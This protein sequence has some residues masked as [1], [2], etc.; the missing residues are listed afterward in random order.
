VFVVEADEYDRSFLALTPTVAVVNNVEADHLDIYRD[1]DDIT[2]AFTE[3][4]RRARFVVACADDAGANELPYPAS[5]EVVRYS[6]ARSAGHPAGVDGGHPDAAWSRTTCASTPTGAPPSSSGTTGKA[7]G[8][9]ALRVPG[10]AQ[11]AQRARRRGRGLLLG[12]E[13][14]AMRP[15]LEG[16]GGVE[17]RFQRLGEAAGGAGGRRLRAPPDRDRGDPRGRARGVPGAPASWP[18]PAAPLLAHARLRRRVRPRAAPPT[19]CSSPRS[20]RRASSRSPA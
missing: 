7:L 3:F 10:R 11:R 20:T 18:L 19:R 16:F 17:R 4:A 2:A 6:V 1:L 5:A 12:A 9:L 8:T 15:G 13:L 14:A